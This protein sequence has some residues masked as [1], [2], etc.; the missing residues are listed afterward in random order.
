MCCGMKEINLFLVLVEEFYE[1]CKVWYWEKQGLDWITDGIEAPDKFSEQSFYY[2]NSCPW[3]VVLKKKDCMLFFKS[4]FCVV[5]MLERSRHW[6]WIIYVGSAWYI[7]LC[8]IVFLLFFFFFFF[9]SLMMNLGRVFGDEDNFE[10]AGVWDDSRWLRIWYTQRNMLFISKCAFHMTKWIKLHY[11]L[12]KSVL[13]NMLV[14]IVFGEWWLAATGYKV[15]GGITLKEKHFCIHSFYFM[16]ILFIW[17]KK[18]VLK[19]YFSVMISHELKISAFFIS[20]FKN[21]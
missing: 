19:S 18:S 10:V 12:Y 1:L 14:A 9:L 17:I 8:Y 16:R 7:K 20:K 6:V 15:W 2:N 11:L 4:Y 13:T 3:Q 5:C 21:L